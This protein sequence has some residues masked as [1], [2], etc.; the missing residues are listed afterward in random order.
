MIESHQP[1]DSE[2]PEQSQTNYLKDIADHLSSI[3][4]MLTFFMVMFILGIII[5]AC[6]ALT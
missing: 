2:N 3:R 4:S 6:G 1:L 5:Q